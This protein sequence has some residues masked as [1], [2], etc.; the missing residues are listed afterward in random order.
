MCP[1]LKTGNLALNLLLLRMNF[2]LKFATLV[3]NDLFLVSIIIQAI[4]EFYNFFSFFLPRTLF[5]PLNV[6]CIGTL[7]ALTGF[8]L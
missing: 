6:R 4:M 5:L 8:F 1:V 7:E 2:V 3:S